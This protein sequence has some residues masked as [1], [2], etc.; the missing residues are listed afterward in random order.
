MDFCNDTKVYWTLGEEHVN[1]YFMMVE[2]CYLLLCVKTGNSDSVMARITTVLMDF[3]LETRVLGF[4]AW[5]SLGKPW[6]YVENQ[7]TNFL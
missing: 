2:Q 4:Y 1:C 3:M 7:A 6:L 5:G